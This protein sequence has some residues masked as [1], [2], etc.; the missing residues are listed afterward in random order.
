MSTIEGGMV[1]TNNTD[2]YDLMRMKRSHGMARVST[3]FADYANAYPNIDKQFLFVTDGYNFRNHE[4]CAVLG[5]SQLGRLNKMIKIR[6]RNHELFSQIIDTYPQMFYNIKNPASNSSF[7]FPFICKSPEIMASMKEVFT[8]YG[9]EYRPVV[10]GNLLTQ[11]FLKDY[12]IDTNRTVTAADIVNNQGVYIGNSHFV[13]EK[14]M[15]FLKQVVG[16]IFEK[17]R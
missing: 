12:K 1:S 4:I 3:R 14:D 10:A 9:I 11:P 6:K 13:T 17:F 8:K 16:E 5:M 7:C 15:V 2:L